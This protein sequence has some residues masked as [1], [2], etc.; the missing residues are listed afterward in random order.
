M[1]KIKCYDCDHEFQAVTREEILSTLYTHY[2]EE[3]KEIITGVNEEEKKAWMERF[4][5]DW[6]EAKTIDV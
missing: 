1:K 4:E 5:K 3:H 2:M 6:S